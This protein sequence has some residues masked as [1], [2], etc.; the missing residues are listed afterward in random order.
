MDIF[1]MIWILIENKL[2]C[3]NSLENR[4]ENPPHQKSDLAEVIDINME[5]ATGLEPATSSLGS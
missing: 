1:L 4:L 2:I 5:R 3:W